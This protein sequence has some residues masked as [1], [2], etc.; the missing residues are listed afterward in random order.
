MSLMVFKIPLLILPQ[1]LTLGLG[2]FINCEIE[3][4]AMVVMM[5][6][7]IIIAFCIHLGFFIIFYNMED[8]GGDIDHDQDQLCA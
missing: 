4:P 8:D 7:Q 5:N 1:V 6:L 3:P 2:G